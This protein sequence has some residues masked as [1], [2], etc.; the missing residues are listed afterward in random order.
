MGCKACPAV[1]RYLLYSRPSCRFRWVFCQLDF[2]RRCLPQRIQRALN[3]LPE[4]LDET[5]ERTLERIDNAKWE[6]AN[7]LFQCIT[8]ASRPLRVDEVAEF[9][10]FDFGDGAVP[11]HDPSWRPEDPEDALLSICS[12]LL[13]VVD[14]PGSK[15]IQFC[16]Y[17]VKEFLT[18]DR[19]AKGRESISRYRVLMQPAHTTIL[20]VCLA[21]LLSLSRDANKETVEDIPL[22]LYAAQHWVDHARFG[23]DSERT[24]DFTRLIFHPRERHFAV[25]TRIHDVLQGISSI[26]TQGAQLELRYASV[27][28]LPDVV[29]FLITKCSQNVNPLSNHSLPTPLYLA[30]SK[31]YDKVIE[32]LLRHG[33]NVNTIGNQGWTALHVASAN[34]HQQATRVLLLPKYNADTNVQDDHGKTPLHCALENGHLGIALSLIKH[35]GDQDI[36]DDRNITPLHIASEKGYLEVVLALLENRADA[37]ARCEGNKTP[38]HRALENKRLEVIQALLKHGVD[39]NTRYDENNTTVLYLASAE[40]YLEAVRTLLEYAA[41][42]NIRDDDMRTPLHIASKEGYLDVVVALL[43][44][45]ADVNALDDELTTP[46][47]GASRNQRLAVVRAL[48]GRDADPNTRD[49][50]NSTPLH[51]G[52]IHGP[53]ELVQVL[54]KHGANMISRD[55]D[56]NTPL[57][58]A[59]KYG[60]ANIVDILLEHGADANSRNNDDRTPLQLMLGRGR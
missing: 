25:W 2:L 15:V 41:D 50:E 60:H 54:L 12:S 1:V 17:S 31:G 53:L 10:A 49:N 47:Y 40:G 16:H 24:K 57:H 19:I 51:L 36:R 58:L 48:L 43:E 13:A 4:T 30:A 38:L 34:G 56:N 52:S 26:D 22:A 32:L 35:P 23:D 8:V 55:N 5:Y 29:E 45:K 46:L 14:R 21:I 28:G 20:Q 44:H 39:P 27:C 9:L 6:Y 11:G 3:E 37:S 59:Y 42:P 18:S 7:R 33:A